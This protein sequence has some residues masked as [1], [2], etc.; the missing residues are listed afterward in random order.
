LGSLSADS[1]FPTPLRPCCHRLYLPALYLPVPSLFFFRLRLSAAFVC[2]HL[3]AGS[4]IAPC[5]AACSS[6]PLPLLFS[7]GFVRAD[8]AEPPLRVHTVSTRLLTCLQPVL[9][10]PGAG[11][12]MRC[13]RMKRFATRG[14][15]LFLAYHP[16]PTA[17]LRRAPSSLLL[18]MSSVPFHWTRRVLP[19]LFLILLLALL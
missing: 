5:S 12:G 8:A 11:R 7:R 18:H 3:Q 19:P 1:A 15:F 16:L 4:A 9:Y 2:R 14:V 6:C 10:I 13:S 17:P